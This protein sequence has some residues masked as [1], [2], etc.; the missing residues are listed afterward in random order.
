METKEQDW[1]L[2]IENGEVFVS[3][4]TYP[5]FATQ[6]II[7]GQQPEMSFSFKIKWKDPEQGRFDWMVKALEFYN[8]HSRQ[9]T[10]EEPKRKQDGD[11]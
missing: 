5:R 4:V 3:H 9:L 2:L 6:I 10:D 7:E 11:L 1:Q 8:K